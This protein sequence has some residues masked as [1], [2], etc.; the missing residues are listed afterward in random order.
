MY[1]LCTHVHECICPFS[2]SLMYR[3]R[4]Y[5]L[6][7]QY[8]MCILVQHSALAVLLS[9]LTWTATFSMGHRTNTS[10]VTTLHLLLLVPFPDP[11]FKPA[12]DRGHSIIPSGLLAVDEINNDSSV[13][14]GYHLEP[15]VGDGGCTVSTKA[16]S[17]MLERVVHRRPNEYIIGIVGPVCSEAARAL[18]DLMNR[19]RIKL[20]L[21]TTGNSPV[22][23]NP[24]KYPFTH[25]IVST[26]DEYA[27]LV[28][29]L[30]KEMRSKGEW[31]TI[32]LFYDANRLYHREIYRGVLDMFKSQNISMDNIYASP[33][34]QDYL[35]LE[36]IIEA[37][38]RIVFV[39]SSKG[40]A[41]ML[42]CRAFT[43][44]IKQ[45]L[46]QLFFTDRT[47]GSFQ[48]CVNGS[49]E[50]VFTY[51]S[52]VHRCTNDQM[53]SAMENFIIFSFNLEA[54]RLEPNGTRAVSGNTIAEYR[55]KY[56]WRLK[57]YNNETVEEE[58]KPNEWAAPFYDAVWAL[59]LA[60]N[61]TLPNLN[62]DS[63]LAI[64]EEDQL[65]HT[66]DALHFRG[67]SA[68][69]DFNT[70]TGFSNSTITISRLERN[71][72]GEIVDVP[73]GYYNAGALFDI[74]N[75]NS[76]EEVLNLYINS[77]FG[78][79]TKMLTRWLSI[80]GYIL[81]ILVLIATI[82]YHILHFYYR[83]RPSLKAASPRLNHLIFLGCYI[84]LASVAL[85]TTDV[86][87][88][89]KS[90]TAH[91]SLCYMVIWFEHIGVALVFSTLLVKFYRLY[92]VFLRTY[93]HRPNLSNGKLS[94]IV[95]GLV[96]VEIAILT[97][98]TPFQPLTIETIVSFDSRSDPP[99]NHKKRICVARG[100]GTWFQI[101]ASLY[102][103]ILIL[104]VVTLSVLNRRIKQR[105][106]NTTV[107]TNILVYLFVFLLS[108]LLPILY[109]IDSSY[110]N[111][112]VK[113]VLINSVYL[114]FTILCLVFLFTPP[115]LVRNQKARKYSLSQQLQKISAIIALNRL[116]SSP[117][118]PTQKNVEYNR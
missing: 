6:T 50:L 67:V 33:I 113:Y 89:P 8:Y 70:K 68:I 26:S 96:G 4:L 25:G 58:L 75:H 42:M 15:I 112:D 27:E 29:K 107:A 2:L 86:G 23:A 41:C 118:S 85:D 37:G 59:A 61:Q 116:E 106:F 13:L 40:P 110:A 99:I 11:L 101:S 24:T 30:Y 16:V 64:W 117:R 38:I 36:D 3:S 1:A 48:T 88:S 44:G 87:F 73:K 20:P 18:S 93:D 31:T 109:I 22:L 10:N 5:S 72:S 80:P 53:V 103:A 55:D 34:S 57:E 7:R 46:Y 51:N 71:G 108:I 102:L 74:S 60:A 52:K 82:T 78:T 39:F 9:L 97:I 94:L 28:V 105:D 115:L 111:I 43:L 66:F 19:N 104:A 12:Y 56:E 114:T 95:M 63:K 76:N 14:N 84:I 32:S 90:T 98:W 17:Q 92:L 47:L 91:L 83:Y 21:I 45:P 69:I 35:P 77:A 100:V 79:S 62:L 81:T 49:D 65:T 54:L